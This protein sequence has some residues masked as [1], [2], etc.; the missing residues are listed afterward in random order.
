[1]GRGSSKIGGGGGGG[2]YTNP[3]DFERKLENNGGFDNPDYAKFEKAYTEESQYNK[4]FEKNLMQV[5]DEGENITKTLNDEERITKREL[6]DMPKNKTAEQIGVEIALKERL[7]VINRLRK[8]KPSK[9]DIDI[10]VE[11]R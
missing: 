2:K 4:G 1:M 7:D 9:R 10:V 8:K 11:R 5:L 3:T 6:K